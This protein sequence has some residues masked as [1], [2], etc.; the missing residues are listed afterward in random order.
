[1]LKVAPYARYST[2]NQSVVS[3]EDQFRFCREHAGR[4]RA[5]KSSIPI[6]TP[7]S[8]VPG[9]QALLQDAQTLEAAIIVPTAPFA[10][11]S[12]LIGQLDLGLQRVDAARGFIERQLVGVL[13]RLI[14]LLGE[15][16]QSQGLRAAH[17]RAHAL[18]DI[19]VFTAAALIAFSCFSNL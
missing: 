3:I 13:L 4:E 7:L 19:A 10:R 1:M 15:A 6:M 11:H 17:L 2:D 8:P 16:L 12:K 5:G 9:V 14:G 18:L